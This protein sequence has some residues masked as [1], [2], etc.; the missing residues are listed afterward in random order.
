MLLSA[1]SPGALLWG[2]GLSWE[3]LPAL[4]DV[5][6]RTVHRWRAAGELPAA[7]VLVCMCFADLGTI[8]EPWRGWMISRRDGLLYSPEGE[9][10]GP[11]DLRALFW[12]RQ[13]IRALARQVDRLQRQLQERPPLPFVP[14]RARY[15]KRPPP[16]THRAKT[17]R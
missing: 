2:A 7:L 3:K 16:P 4:L 14:A 9:A 8:S 17:A 13:R 12:H 15:H 10:F 11:G 5:S 6:T 1:Q